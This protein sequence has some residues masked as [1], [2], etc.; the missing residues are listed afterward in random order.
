MLLYS[1]VITD[2]IIFAG[3]HWCF[4]VGTND[5]IVLLA[6]DLKKLIWFSL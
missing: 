6:F 4:C 3:A 2:I 5:S 1:F